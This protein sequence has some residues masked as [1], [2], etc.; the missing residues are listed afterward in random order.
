M[1]RSRW[2]PLWLWAVA[3]FGIAW[4]ANRAQAADV[5]QAVRSYQQGFSAFSQQQYK[6]AITKFTK[7]RQL[8]PSFRRYDKTRVE[9]D[10]LIG[11]SYYHLRKFQK[12]Y[13]LL[14]NYLR[15]PSR[16]RSKVPAVRKLWLELRSR[17]GFSVKKTVK[18]RVV[19]IVRRV[20]PP[21][22]TR[23][24]PPRRTPPPIQRRASGPHPGAWAIA[25]IGL[26]TLG[27]AVAVGILA[28][29]NMNTVQE[30]YNRL[31]VLPERNAGAISE[32][33]REALTQSTVANA[34]YVGGGVFI[35]TG[36][37]L[38]FTWKQ[39]PPKVP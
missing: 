7:A 13:S 4:G 10:R 6:E 19:P 18:R 2:Y 5:E 37:L 27:A 29:Q 21:I 32:G 20:T 26:A 25:G 3:L 9:L 12:A 17:L 28:Q 34:L 36:T 24:I 22:R 15:S 38:L 39:A 33:A 11:V 16:R 1:Q 31:A 30:R 8:L 14:D 23:V 35:A